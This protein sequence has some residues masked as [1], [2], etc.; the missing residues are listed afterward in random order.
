LT[1]TAETL[2][3]TAA[4]GAKTFEVKSN[5]AWTITGHAGAA[6]ITAVSP[7]S[8]SGNATVSVTAGANAS[9]TA[10]RTATL[11]ITAAGV[12][13]RTVTIHQEKESSSGGVSVSALSAKWEIADSN[14]PYAS[15]EF[16]ED[17]NYIVVENFDLDLKRSGIIS[18]ASLFKGGSL[19][20]RSSESE[21]NL[22]TIHFGTY[23]IEGNN[24]I[25]EGFGLIEAISITAEEFSFSFTLDATGTKNQFVAGKA[26]EPVS[27]S[28]RTDLLCRTWIVESFTIDGEVPDD[29]EIEEYDVIGKIVLFSKAGT[30]LVLGTDGEAG[31]AEWKW[32]NAEETAFYFSWDNWEED[33]DWE[34]NIVTITQ[35]T[36]NSMIFE[37]NYWFSHW[38]Y[39]LTLKK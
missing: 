20:I 10:T 31:I 15:F 34:E 16:T 29:D 13:P 12:T 4:G 38:V 36:E 23:Q 35:L 18:K 19:K 11:T 28:S 37:E 27:S 17:G 5:T 2:E 1:V 14:S 33:D 25:L 9:T 39:Y 8:G 3:F 7:A 30:Y 32:A 21:T 6:W 22:P 26:D 24:I